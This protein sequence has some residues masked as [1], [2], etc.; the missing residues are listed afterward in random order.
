[1]RHYRRYLVIGAPLHTHTQAATA[2]KRYR[3]FFARAAQIDGGVSEQRNMWLYRYHRDANRSAGRCLV[4][5][6]LDRCNRRKNSRR[7]GAFIIARTY[8]RRPLRTLARRWFS[9]WRPARERARAR[10]R[11]VLRQKQAP[12]SRCVFGTAE[13][14]TWQTVTTRRAFPF[15]FIVSEHGRPARG[16]FSGDERTGSNAA[17]TPREMYKSLDFEKYVRVR[18]FVDSPPRGGDDEKKKKIIS[19]TWSFF[20]EWYLIYY[21]LCISGRIYIGN[22]ILQEFDAYNPVFPRVVNTRVLQSRCQMCFA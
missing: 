9:E 14:T 17:S 7:C 11:G 8:F 10:G 6:T 5:S 21:V 19:V 20:S 15:A 16:S 3:Y 18:A 13:W 1:M 2:A 22:T 4:N 12:L